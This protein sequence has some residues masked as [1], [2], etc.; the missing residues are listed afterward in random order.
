MPF[1]FNPFTHKL[2]ETSSGGGGT[3]ILT[4]TGNTGG[5][6]G[7]DGANNI[8]IIGAGAILIDGDPM[9]NTLTVSSSFPFFSWFVITSSQMAITQQGYFTNDVA[10]IDLLL[11]N[12]SV[13]GDLFIVSD[14]GGNKWRITQD[15]GQQIIFGSSSTTIGATG[16]IESIF[17]GDSVTLVCCVANTTWMALAPIGNITIV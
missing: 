14:L 12:V 10:R 5:A 16:Y 8:N 7:A 11:P 15:S 1:K 17:Q 13:V 9:T 3:G 4:V 2:D 6:I